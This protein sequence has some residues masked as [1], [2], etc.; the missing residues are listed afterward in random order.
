MNIQKV[1]DREIEKNE[2]VTYKH[3]I[4]KLF[5]DRSEEVFKWT[6]TAKLLNKSGESAQVVRRALHD[7]WKTGEVARLK[8]EGR[9]YTY[10]GTRAA[11]KKFKDAL[12]KQHLNYEDKTKEPK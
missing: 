3:Q 11:M 6:E 1:V 2:G 5:G 7:L 4:L 8:I 9:K 12:D 10:Y